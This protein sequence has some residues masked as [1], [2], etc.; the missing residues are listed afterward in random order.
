MAHGA[1]ASRYHR[2]LEPVQA[3]LEEAP[4]PTLRDNEQG[5]H[6]SCTLGS[7]WGRLLRVLVRLGLINRPNSSKSRERHSSCAL[8]VV[9]IQVLLRAI[10]AEQRPS[11]APLHHQY[12]LEEQIVSSTLTTKA[13]TVNTADGKHPWISLSCSAAPILNL[14]R[15]Q[16]GR[17]IP[18]WWSFSIA[19][20]VNS[21]EQPTSHASWPQRKKSTAPLRPKTILLDRNGIRC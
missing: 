5:A 3:F 17:P 14:A 21:V 19:N 6:G 7:R 12:A 10:T 16:I 2:M 11:D 8:H 15:G 18:A 9:S 1:A 13:L 20:A 4:T